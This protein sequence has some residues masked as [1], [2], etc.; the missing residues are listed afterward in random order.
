MEN[1]KHDEIIL[2][3]IK[4]AYDLECIRDRE[5]RIPLHK[6]TVIEGV[7]GKGKTSL[8]NIILGLSCVTEGNI[9]GNLLDYSVVFQEDRL[10]ES[11][12]GVKN[13]QAVTSGLEQEYI[14]SELGKLLPAS[15]IKKPVN[16]YSGGMKRRVAIV[17]AMLKASDV[18]IMDEP[19]AGLDEELKKKTADYVLKKLNGRTLIIAVHEKDEA[20]YFKPEN[21]IS[22]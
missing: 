1:E 4:P 10:L 13:I 11:L 21:I 12:S 17:R 2:K 6:I 22:L 9:T 15:Y 19:F 18:V 14:E 8:I 20:H 16:T 5:I 3:N 7:S